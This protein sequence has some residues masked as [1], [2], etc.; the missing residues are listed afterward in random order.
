MAFHSPSFF[1]GFWP[2]V[3]I[4]MFILRGAAPKWRTVVLVLAS[5]LF[6]ATGDP[7]HLPL[8]VVSFLGNHWLGNQL[9]RLDVRN[10]WGARWLVIGVVG[11]LVPLAAFKYGVAPTAY[12][13]LDAT[14][15][16]DGRIPLGLS[17]YTF[18]QIAYLVDVRTTRRGADSLLDYSIYVGFFAQIPAG[19]I[20]RFSEYTQRSVPL[21]NV[22]IDG[23]RVCRGI[24]LFA[25]GLAKKVLLADLLGAIVDPIHAANDAGTPPTILEAWTVTWAFMLQLYFDFSGYSD[26]AIGIGLT[27]GF[28]LPINFR[29]PLKAT[30]LAEFY[31]RWHITLTGFFRSFVMSPLLM[32]SVRVL[33]PRAR[34]A[35]WAVATI[36]TL[37]LIGVWHGARPTFI[38]YG[39]ATGVVAVATQV[40]ATVKGLRGTALMRWIARVT[41]F[42]TLLFTSACFRAGSLSSVF[43]LLRA[44]FDPWNLSVS[45]QVRD[46][47]RPMVG[48]W[49]QGQGFFPAVP[50][51]LLEVVSILAVTSI[52]AL[53]FPNTVDVFGLAG[54]DPTTQAR[55]NP[56]AYRGLTWTPNRFW[57]I[58]TGL[59]FAAA[60]MV[61]TGSPLTTNIYGRF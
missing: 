6:Y 20:V 33:G 28:C 52:I 10:P 58:S 36:V 50:L 15:S 54:E 35:G 14:G 55:S 18:Q 2:A 60:I 32:A 42:A 24:S 13:G 27:L 25:V 56:K 29:S 47:L 49:V 38:V 31:D 26:M 41:L 61:L 48:A 22:A 44:M 40:L 43:A 59:L 53:T 19:P 21:R 30:S 16:G 45:E 3:I 1:L 7:V 51:T 5:A 9:L 11:N 17:F 23:H 12:F 57:A 39:V 37:T 46:I 4:A 8:L 34:V